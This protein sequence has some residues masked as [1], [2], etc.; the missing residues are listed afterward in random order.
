MQNAP[1][2]QQFKG[3]FGELQI[4][5]IAG[6]HLIPAGNIDRQAAYIREESLDILVNGSENFSIFE[7][8]NKLFLS[9]G[10]M[11]GA[12]KDDGR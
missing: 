12:T 5:L 3:T 2:L 10:S 4:G 8:N 11:T 1:Y 9:P 6:D 7:E